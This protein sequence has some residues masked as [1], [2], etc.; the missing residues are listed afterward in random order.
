MK[1]I[2]RN[3]FKK[4]KPVSIILVIISLIVGTII[5][6]FDIMMWFSLFSEKVSK[7]EIPF[8]SIFVCFVFGLFGC[9]FLIFSIIHLIKHILLKQK[10]L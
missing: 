5:I 4:D 7:E 9:V 2:K 1:K 3:N 8:L 6:S 10:A